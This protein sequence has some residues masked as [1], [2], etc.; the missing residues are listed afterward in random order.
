MI[1]QLEPMIAKLNNKLKVHDMKWGKYK[2][3]ETSIESRV[4][5]ALY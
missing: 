1:H 3:N 5:A 4:I 2:N